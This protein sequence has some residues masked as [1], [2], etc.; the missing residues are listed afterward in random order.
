EDLLRHCRTHGLT[1][2]E[3]VLQNE[4][5]SRGPKEIKQ[6]LLRIWETMK[7]CIYRGCHTEG[8]LPG[9]LAV[10]RRAARLNRKL[11]GEARFADADAWIAAI[12]R[13]KPA[14]TDVLQWVSC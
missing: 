9:G 14:F 10:V 5:A 12:R 3:V 13:S 6:G 11:L 2:P 8:T 4:R 1:I 7:Q